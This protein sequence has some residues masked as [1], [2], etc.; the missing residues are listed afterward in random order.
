MHSP[1]MSSVIYDL[2]IQEATLASE[3]LGRDRPYP[4]GT[5]PFGSHNEELHVSR[6]DVDSSV[7]PRRRQLHSPCIAVYRTKPCRVLMLSH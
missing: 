6:N 5:P 4:V 1:M 7:R 2:A 3:F